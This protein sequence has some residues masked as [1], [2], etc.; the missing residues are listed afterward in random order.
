MQPFSWQQKKGK[1]HLPCHN[2]PLKPLVETDS[3]RRPLETQT[4]TIRLFSAFS[5]VFNI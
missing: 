2:P 4:S 5:H 1:I 3:H